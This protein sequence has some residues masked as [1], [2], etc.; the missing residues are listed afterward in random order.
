M[1]VSAQATIGLSFSSDGGTETAEVWIQELSERS[2]CDL[3][4]SRG[5]SN[6]VD[7][8]AKTVPKDAM[9]VTVSSQGITL[10][11]DPD[12]RSG[13]C[14]GV[15]YFL[16]RPHGLQRLDG[17]QRPW[18]S[19]RRGPQGLTGMSHITHPERGLPALEGAM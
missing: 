2:E 7:V 16:M 19:G 13:R 9:R 12:V 14:V 1:W 10:H 18:A 15:T 4:R 17:L 3:G 8:P 11:S 5:D 6:P